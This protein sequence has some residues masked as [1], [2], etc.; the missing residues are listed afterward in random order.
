MTADRTRQID[1]SGVM[2]QE[3]VHRSG[4]LRICVRPAKKKDSLFCLEG[5][6]YADLSAPA[7]EGEANDRLFRNMSLW[8]SWPISKIRVEK[9]KTS[10]RKTIVI[11]GLSDVE[12]RDR[13]LGWLGKSSKE[14]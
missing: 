12:I 5:D 1:G 13:L 7:R 3:V 6:F 2:R 4:K 11:E 8:L 9:G 10:R 14:S